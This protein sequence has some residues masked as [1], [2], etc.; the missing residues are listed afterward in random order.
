MHLQI[1]IHPYQSLKVKFVKEQ[2]KLALLKFQRSYL[3]SDLDDFCIRC[4]T[5][6]FEQFFLIHLTDGWSQ[7]LSYSQK[8]VDTITVN[9]AHNWSSIVYRR[10]FF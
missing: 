1:Y 7:L 10:K 5:Q 3:P 9:T 2:S 4:K 8:T 6:H